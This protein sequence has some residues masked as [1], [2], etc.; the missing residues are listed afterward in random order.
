V[1]IDPAN[2]FSRRNYEILLDELKTFAETILSKY[3]RIC[4]MTRSLGSVLTLGLIPTLGEINEARMS[5]TRGAILRA[6][7]IWGSPSAYFSFSKRARHLRPESDVLYNI[8]NFTI[9]NP[10]YECDNADYFDSRNYILLVVFDSKRKNWEYNDAVS[11]LVYLP[12]HEIR[13]ELLQ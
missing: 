13:I 1:A 12:N 2:S 5:K 9:V 8:E 3:R 6:P 4:F 11:G 10:Q 7:A